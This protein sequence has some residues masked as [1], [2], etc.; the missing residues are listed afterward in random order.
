MLVFDRSLI[1]VCIYELEAISRLRKSS[2]MYLYLINE[3][4]IDEGQHQYNTS[5]CQG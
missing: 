5:V 3:H 2:G 1:K 4:F